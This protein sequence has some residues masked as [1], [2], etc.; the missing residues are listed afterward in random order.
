M[1]LLTPE[2]REEIRQINKIKYQIF[3]ENETPEELAKRREVNNERSRRSRAKR[4]ANES[5]EERAERL[6]RYRAYRKEWQKRIDAKKQGS[7]DR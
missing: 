4:L 1:A 6:A 7:G 3:I 2:E 5:E